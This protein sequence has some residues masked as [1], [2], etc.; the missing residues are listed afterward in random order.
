MALLSGSTGLNTEFMPA[1]GDFRIQVTGG[2]VSLLSKP[3]GGS[4]FVLEVALGANE[5]RLVYNA[6]AGTVYKWASGTP[7]DP[8]NPRA[9]Q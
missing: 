5:T 6:I 2:S 7:A 8:A 9:D 3:A 4:D 1:V